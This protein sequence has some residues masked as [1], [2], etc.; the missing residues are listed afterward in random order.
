MH[1]TST[2]LCCA[3]VLLLALPTAAQGQT[4]VEKFG[5][6]ES[7]AP[8]RENPRW[9]EPRKIVVD[10]GVAG[11]ADALRGVL[12]AATVVAANPGADLIAAVADADVLIGRSLV[13]CAAPVLLAARELRWIQSVY[14]GVEVCTS[15]PALVERNVLLTN[16]RAMA[17]PV[18]AEHTFALLLGLTRGLQ[19]WLP[20]QQ[21]Q[22]WTRD[23]SNK[24]LR[25]LAG[26]TM[27]V[28][29]LGGMGMRVI[30]TRATPQ[31]RPDYVDYVGTAEELPSLLP[32]ADV[33]VNALPLTSS[34]RGL[35]AAPLFARTKRGAF[36]INV[37][38]GASVVS[39][40]LAAALQSGQLGGAGLDVTEPEPLP[41]DHPLWRAPNIIISPHIAGESDLGDAPQIALLR[42]NLQRY[43]SGG[44]MLS[45][46]DLGRGY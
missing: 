4:L 44:R 25:T 43:R 31:A 12:P 33:I 6:R 7:Q 35:F 18:I 13:V 40:D 39:L 46:V 3:L 19:W 5:L 26:Q 17:S 27:L 38:R 8:I 32:Q 15:Q 9:R 41:A 21:R 29:G 1:P 37:G 10:A 14:A 36:F 20:A 45:V 16:M 23:F 42:E 24:P 34:T 22:D 28:V 11:L 2:R 30:A